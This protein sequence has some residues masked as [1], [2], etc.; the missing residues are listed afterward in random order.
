MPDVVFIIAEKN[1][2][3]EELLNTKEII[4]AAG[5]KTCIA[6]KTKGEKKGMLGAIA[7]ADFSL[8][9]VN[10]ENYKAI[11]F[12]GGQGCTAYFD[13]VEALKI[14]KDAAEKGKI[15]A[16]ICI[17]PVVLAN[18]GL[19]EGKKATVWNGDF[20]AAIK[21]KGA[22]YVNRAVVKDGNIITA[23]G[24]AAARQFGNTIV[25]ALQR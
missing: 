19:L 6:A 18:A 16:A 4:E 17:A 13:D 24:P 5:L 3:D 15:V 20:I 12:V 8:R 21:A 11:I 23:N 10:V 2:R 22:V 14:A 25:D 7:K 1:L 9:E